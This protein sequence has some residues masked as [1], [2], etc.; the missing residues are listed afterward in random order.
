MKAKFFVLLFI[1]SFFVS[2]C[3]AIDDIFVQ[4][5]ETLKWI[6]YA[7]TSFDPIKEQYPNADSVISDLKSLREAGF[8][9]IVTY[10]SNDILG[11]I[12]KFAKD[13]GFKGVIMGVWN[14]KSKEELDNAIS[15]AQY[16]D[17][18]CLGNEGL[19][20]R[21][22][23]DELK[24]AMGMVREKTKR[25]VATTEEIDDYCKD[26]MFELG[27][28]I[29]PNAHPVMYAISEPSKAVLWATKYYSLL[30]R[31]SLGKPVLFKETGIPTRGRAGCNESCQKKFFDLLVKTGVKFVY[32][33][34]Y[35]QLWKRFYSSE[36]YWGLFNSKREPKKFAKGEIKANQCQLSHE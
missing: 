1:S 3:L 31:K 30:K 21:Y 36:P 2:P 16:V 25:P 14:I 6:A 33:E 12:P 29:F 4:K 26:Y 24:E 35:D 34:A 18:Y 28:W 5:L 32:F 20:R 9:G 19:H 15:A 7:P 27:D 8:N 17:G 23:V 13:A 22:E 11:L 10:S